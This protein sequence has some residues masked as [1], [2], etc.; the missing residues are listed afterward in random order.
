MFDGNQDSDTIVQNK[1]SPPVTARYIRLVPF[2]WKNKISMRMEI[3]GC[4]GIFYNQQI[5]LVVV[6]QVVVGI[7][8]K[9][10]SLVSTQEARVAF[11]CASSNV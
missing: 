3:Y 10:G 5:K 9:V 1:L 7:S 8:M 4:P 2:E 6:V 11:G